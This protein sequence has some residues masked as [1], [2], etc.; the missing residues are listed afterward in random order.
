M[1]R[2]HLLSL[3]VL[4]LGT[5]SLCAENLLPEFTGDWVNGGPYTKAGVKE[6]IVLFYLVE[7]G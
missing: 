7:R 3:V 6:K 5:S 1:R 4:F 2:H